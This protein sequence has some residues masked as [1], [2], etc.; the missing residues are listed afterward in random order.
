MANINLYFPK[1]VAFEGG[2]VMD[3]DDHGHETNMGITLTTW[4]S[5]GYDKNR[6]G[7]IDGEDIRLLT[8][9]DVLMVLRR[10]FWNRWQAELI[11]NQSIAEQLVDWTW[12][13]GKWGIIWPQ[14]LLAIKADGIVGNYTLASVNSASPAEFHAKVHNAR[15]LFSQEICRRDPSQEKFLKGW[16]NRI[17]S[18]KFQQ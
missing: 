12:T 11:G 5:M 17:H 16:L 9:D 8:R 4:K 1:V 10:G 7:I 14:R 13:S 18:F 15:V 3:P 2:F 6:D